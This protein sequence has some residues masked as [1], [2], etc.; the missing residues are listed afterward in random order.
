[1]PEMKQTHKDQF[2]GPREDIDFNSIPYVEKQ[3]EASRLLKLKEYKKT[4][5][6]PSSKKKKVV[7]LFW[8]NN[9]YLKLF[10]YHSLVNIRVFKSQ[11][12]LADIT[13]NRRQRK[14]KID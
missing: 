1:M 12:V 5:V 8:N 14:I 4:G 3:R 7:S 6:W 13:K 10:F 9:Y 2:V 11:G